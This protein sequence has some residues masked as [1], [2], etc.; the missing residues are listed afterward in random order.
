MADRIA[1]MRK[2]SIVELGSHAELMA[3]EG[4][5][6][7]LFRLHRKWMGGQKEEGPES[8]D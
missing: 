2:G 1:V 4:M 6:A 7:K 8:A 5:Y 3:E